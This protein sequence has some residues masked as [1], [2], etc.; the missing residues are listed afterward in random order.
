MCYVV[1][2]GVCTVL[3]GSMGVVF[4]AFCDLYVFCKYYSSIVFY[5]AFI[6]GCGVSLVYGGL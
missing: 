2:I 4:C 5:S 3:G 1:V 6:G